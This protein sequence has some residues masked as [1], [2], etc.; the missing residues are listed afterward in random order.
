MTID[1]FAD[2]EFLSD[3]EK[4]TVG[5]C[6][7]A[8]IANAL[9]MPIADVPHF[10]R[11]HDTDY[12]EATQEWLEHKGELPLVFCPPT[13]P[14]VDIHLRFAILLGRSPRNVQ[15]AVLVDATTGEIIHD[16]H[17]SRAGLT[18]RTGVYVFY[19]E[20]LSL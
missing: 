20:G 11:D 8:C 7:R 19:E 15:H 2:Q 3:P 10:V 12:V 6:W 17:P 4:G 1:N 5:D 18:T 14:I 13:F 16:P 9:S